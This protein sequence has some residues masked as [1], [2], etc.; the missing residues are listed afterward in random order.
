MPDFATLFH[1]HWPD[2]LRFSVFL[3]GNEAEAEDLAAEAFLRAWTSTKPIRVGTVKSYL[4]MIVRNLYRDRLRRRAA[5]G[6][7]NDSLPSPHPGPDAAACDRAELDRVVAA[8]QLLP[9]SDRA[10]LAMSAF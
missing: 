3:C 8:M 7:P 1:R 10:I 9:E 5:A 4:F 6:A 2:V